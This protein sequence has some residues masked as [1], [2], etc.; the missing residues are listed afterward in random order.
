NRTSRRLQAEAVP[1]ESE[2]IHTSNPTSKK[3]QLVVTQYR[4][5]KLF[6]IKTMNRLLFLTT[7]GWQG[8]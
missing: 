7:D 3:L 4:T 2:A 1:S 5:I 6:L 8:S